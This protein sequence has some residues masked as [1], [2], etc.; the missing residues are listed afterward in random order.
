[1]RDRCLRC[2]EKGYHAKFCRNVRI[3]FNRGSLGHISSRCSKSTPPSLHPIAHIF[4]PARFKKFSWPASTDLPSMASSIAPTHSSLLHRIRLSDENSAK[5]AEEVHNN[6]LFRS[7]VEVPPSEILDGLRLVFPPSNMWKVYYLG[8]CHYQIQ[9]PETRRREMAAIGSIVLKQCRFVV[10]SKLSCLYSQH[11]GFKL[12]ICIYDLEYDSQGYHD[13]EVVIR[14]FGN[15]LDLDFNARVRF[16]LRFAR[17]YV[18]VAALELI[19]RFLW[20]EVT[21]PNGWVFF[22]R[23]RY[24]VEDATVHVP[25]LSVVAVPAALPLPTVPA[26]GTVPV[27]PPPVT[28]TVP[29]W[30]SHP[31]PAPAIGTAPVSRPP[32]FRPTVRP[33]SSPTRPPTLPPSAQPSAEPLQPP[34]GFSTG[35]ST[36][37]TVPSHSLVLKPDNFKKTKNKVWYKHKCG[38][39]QPAHTLLLAEN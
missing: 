33:S 18:E 11:K 13:L 6:L 24:E 21:R 14:P 23:I 30:P 31:P 25:H 19:P 7:E 22:A 29:V 34:S 26:A 32:L 27:R 1:M 12:W 17:V 8:S 3:C 5:L 38:Q 15:I 4:E 37:K 10:S 20:F 36:S 35:L 2:G 9:G 16:D 39:Q 28:G